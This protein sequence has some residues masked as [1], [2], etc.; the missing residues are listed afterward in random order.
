MKTSVP[1][2]DASKI[3]IISIRLLN[4]NIAS[5]AE[6]IQ[7]H[8]P[9]GCETQL[10]AKNGVNVQ[11]KEF[12]SLLTVNL[13]AVDS[14]HEQVGITGE[15]T[16]EVRLKVE[17][18]TDYIIPIENNPAVVIDQSLTGTL[19]SIVYSTSRGI[20]FMRTLGTVLEGVILPVV[21]PLQIQG[22]NI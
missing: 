17:N 18:L 6:A 16:L 4:G 15:Y 2:I 1:P 7:G 5:T 12:I 19:M 20:I 8:V 11:N 13:I 9:F 21:N 10:V 3:S 22:V 14:N